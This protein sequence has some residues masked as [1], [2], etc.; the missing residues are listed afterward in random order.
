MHLYV[1]RLIFL[2]SWQGVGSRRRERW[3]VMG[4]SATE[5]NARCS[6]VT[7]S[8]VC[9]SIFYFTQSP[10]RNT[11]S[12]SQLLYHNARPHDKLY[13]SALP[14]LCAASAIDT[15]TTNHPNPQSPHDPRLQPHTPESS[16]RQTIARKAQT[17]VG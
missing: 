13:A 5:A 17:H 16:S 8:I 6:S 1:V 14:R 2:M 9:S 3:T 15:H 12:P 7:L 4:Q 11:H 10:P